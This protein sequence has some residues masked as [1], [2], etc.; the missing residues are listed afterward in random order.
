MLLLYCDITPNILLIADKF[1]NVICYYFG[2]VLFL[3]Q[4]KKYHYVANLSVGEEL[5]LNSSLNLQM[6]RN[7]QIVTLQKIIDER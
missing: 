7:N 1:V 2:L 4:L 3:E 5:R 6:Q